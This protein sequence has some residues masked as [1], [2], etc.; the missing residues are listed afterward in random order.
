MSH[1][2]DCN[3]DR[4]SDAIDGLLDEKEL[5]AFHQ[6][7]E[8]CP[9]CSQVYEDLQQVSSRLQT[10]PEVTVPHDLMKGVRKT[11]REEMAT[12]RKHSRTSG[13]LTMLTLSPWRG[14]ALAGATCLVAI[15]V[16]WGPSQNA[17]PQSCRLALELNTVEE[18]AGLDVELG[19]SQEGLEAGKPV[20]PAG[21]GDF[22]VASHTQG[23]NMRVS[24]ASA[25]VIH[26]SQKTCILE[27]P[28][29]QRAGSESGTDAIRILSVRA[30]RMDGKP[31]Q[32]EITATPML[33]TRD[34]KLN[35]TA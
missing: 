7:L 1:S 27:L 33:P 6:H 15:L 26:P 3:S 21:L 8:K 35:T 25:Q 10:L 17:A 14:L 22:V 4:I 19:L 12:Q 28:L 29:T 31:A 11:L 16:L 18:I 30:Y 5:A 23:S 2:P 24:M 32:V 20:V 13:W 9:S 34:S